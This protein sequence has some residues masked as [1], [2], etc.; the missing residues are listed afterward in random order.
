MVEKTQ[1]EAWYIS[2][3]NKS[4]WPSHGFYRTTIVATVPF[5]QTKPQ[6]I[7]YFDDVAAHNDW[8]EKL[9]ITDKRVIAVIE[10]KLSKNSKDML[11][12]VKEREF[13]DDKIQAQLDEI[14]KL[15]KALEDKEKENEDL[16]I[17]KK[18]LEDEN[19]SIT[20][21]SID[22]EKQVKALNKKLKKATK[23]KKSY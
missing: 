15:K 22:V 23:A 18:E 14:E 12:V 21:K 1:L 11:E 8:L 10:G 19:A 5:K 20:E 2:K 7:K 4:G 9:K 17:V 6:K 13:A 3:L 16:L